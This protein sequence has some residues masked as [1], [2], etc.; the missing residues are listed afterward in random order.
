MRPGESETEWYLRMLLQ[1]LQSLA[2]EAQTLIRAWP[3]ML[4]AADETVADLDVHLERAGR[5]VDEG[6]ITREM[7][8][9]AR[10]VDAKIPR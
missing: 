8:E 7:W 1:E 5:A 3:P 6:L 9:K 10:A 2:S 4:P